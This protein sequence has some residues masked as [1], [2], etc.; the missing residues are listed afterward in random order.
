VAATVSPRETPSP[1]LVR[2]ASVRVVR[3][4]RVPSAQATHIP[5]STQTKTVRL[6]VPVAAVGPPSYEAVIRSADGAEVWRQDDLAPARG[7]E[8]VVVEIPA[9]VL[10]GDSYQFTLEGE[11]VR[12][13]SG[14][15][16]VV[17]LRFPLRVQ[18][19]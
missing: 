13:P 19:R 8:P 5:V 7:G 2:E 15:E 17:S 9:D 3:L 1:T 11:A 18:H 10:T 14:T 12:D 6:E 16:K 4:P